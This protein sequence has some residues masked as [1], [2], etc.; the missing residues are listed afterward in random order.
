[1]D[2][3]IPKWRFES[4]GRKLLSIFN[5]RTPE[6]RAKSHL[7]ILQLRDM[8][9]RLLTHISYLLLRWIRLRPIYFFFVPS[10]SRL[11]EAYEKRKLEKKSVELSVIISQKLSP[12]RSRWLISDGGDATDKLSG[13]EVNKKKC[14]Q[15]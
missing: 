4:E 7:N 1:M 5:C 11:G 10:P 13:S 2:R 12:S 15:S 3:H 8:L 9:I 14:C 6:S